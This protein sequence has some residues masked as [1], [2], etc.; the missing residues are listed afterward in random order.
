MVLETSTEHLYFT[1][2]VYKETD[3]IF[4]ITSIY[5]RATLDSAAGRVENE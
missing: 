5:H 2:L 4:R 3:L 1:F